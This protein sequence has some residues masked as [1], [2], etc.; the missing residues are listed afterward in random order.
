MA[1]SI[2]IWVADDADGP[3]AR[4]RYVAQLVFE[5]ILGC[6]HHWASDRSD[7]LESPHR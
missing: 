2:I 6:P 3:S 5:V 4:H 7:W 1:E